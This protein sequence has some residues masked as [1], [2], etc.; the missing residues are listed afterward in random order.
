MATVP[1]ALPI[2]LV[3]AR[4]S[5]MKRSTG[6]PIRSRPTRSTKPARGGRRPSAWHRSLPRRRC[7][8]TQFISSVP[9]DDPINIA[10]G[11]TAPDPTTCTDALAVLQRY[12]I[13]VPPAI[14]RLPR[15]G[16]GESHNRGPRHCLPSRPAWSPPRRWRSKPWGVWRA[17][18]PQ[19]IVEVRALVGDKV[20]IVAKLE[21]PAAI[22]CLEQI[23]AVTNAVMVARGDLGVEMPAEQVPSIQKRIV[24]A[25][26]RTGKPVIVATEML[27]SMFDPRGPRGR[28]G[29][30]VAVPASLQLTVSLPTPAFAV[31]LLFTFAAL[32]RG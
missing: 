26:W 21:K 11:A 6:R 24:H 18:S 25:C 29:A 12:A 31:T 20:G 1:T 22:D 17:L 23:V 9:G 7:R 4:A 30:G 10:S 5:D 2:A 3:M 19:D 14:G 32:S 8:R 16:A 28:P 13:E 27:E 15:S